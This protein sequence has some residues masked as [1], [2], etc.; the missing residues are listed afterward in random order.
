M[1]ITTK[2]PPI[3]ETVGAQYICMDSMTEDNDW[4]E[5]FEEDVTKLETVK[6]INVTEASEANDV[7]A[8]GKVYDSDTTTSSAGIE[9]EQIA[10]PENLLAEMRG[11]VVDEGGL[12]LSGGDGIRPYFAFGKVVKLK[13]GKYRYDWYPKCKLTENSDETATSEESPAEQTDTINISAYPFNDHNDIKSMVTYEN[14]PEGLTEDKWFAKPILTVSD[15][16]SAISSG[17]G[18]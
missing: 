1:A 18:E 17:S 8:S 4:T 9:V 13:G 12:T 3:K 15:L 5:K 11:D 7:Y 2:K 10:F 16:E 6:S 14:M